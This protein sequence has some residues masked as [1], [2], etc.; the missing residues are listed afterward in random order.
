MN[1]HE[2]LQYDSATGSL[3]WKPRHDR[4]F[5]E[6]SKVAGNIHHTRYLRFHH[7][8][9]EYLAHRVVWEMH[10][11]PIPKGKMIDHIDG[12]QINNRIENLRLADNSQNQFNSGLKVNNTSGFRGVTWNKK[13]RCWYAQ[14]RHG[15]SNRHLGSF[16][17]AKD[18]S[19]AYEAA[20]KEVHAEFF[21]AA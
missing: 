12:D 1:W 10:H 6:A 21:R 7:K 14:I 20:A 18:A 3:V 11:G 15:G 8:S 9:R 19:N 17:T 2:I 4:S 16:A 13:N 5:G